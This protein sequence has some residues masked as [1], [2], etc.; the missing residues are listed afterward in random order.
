MLPRTPAV[1]FLVFS[2]LITQYR[3][4]LNMS[5]DASFLSDRVAPNM[6]RYSQMTPLAFEGSQSLKMF[7]PTN[8]ST[9]TQDNNV[10]RIPISSGNAFLDG[11][12]SYLKLQFTNTNA[13]PAGIYT[14]SNS[15]HS[16][17]DRVRVIASSGQELENIMNYAHTHAC[18]SDLLLSPEKRMSR[19]QEGYG[20]NGP[21]TF[22]ACG[23]PA[24]LADV[25]DVVN[26]TLASA[27][28]NPLTQGCGETVVIRN[29]VTQVYIPLELSQLVGA[30]KKLLPLFLTGELTLEI[31][32]AQRPCL[33]ADL[34]T[35]LTYQV[36]NV[37]YCGSMVEFSGSVN[38]AL[39]QMVADSG[40]FLHANCWSSQK[41]TLAVGQSSFV[42][43]ERLKSVKSVLVSFTDEAWAINVRPTNRITNGI[44]SLQIKAGSSYFPPQPI[45][46]D[47]TSASSCGWYLNE[48]YKALSVYN[49]VGHSGVVNTQN[50]ASSAQ[51]VSQVGR[52]VYGLDLDA[53]GKDPVESGLNTILNNPLTV[54]MEGSVGGCAVITHL[55]YDAIFHIRPD[56]SFVCVK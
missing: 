39:T 55:L 23:V 41:Q 40:L 24:G 17:I 8:Q 43:S 26:A 35:P 30:N 49:D 47:A 20:V 51:S 31:T 12:N 11:G 22:T 18:L 2:F 9:Y 10:I 38:S 53:F 42:N 37:A 44:Q 46:A 6:I 7:F 34:T 29:G 27:R 45:R 56:G 28:P 52:A 15:F 5:A 1:R 21:M 48:T 19:L 33:V 14:F 54:L 3:S 13:T 25:D 16:L 4:Q 32:L 36:A 50:F